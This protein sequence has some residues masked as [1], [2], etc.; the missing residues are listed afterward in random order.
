MAARGMLGSRRVASPERLTDSPG[1]HIP[2][3]ARIASQL[4]R[5][6]PLTSQNAFRCVEQTGES[7]GANPPTRN[8][9]PLTSGNEPA[10]SPRG[11]SDAV[12]VRCRQ[13]ASFE[14]FRAPGS[15]RP[16]ARR[17]PESDTHV[18]SDH[19]VGHGAHQLRTCLSYQA[20]VF[21]LDALVARRIADVALHADDHPGFELA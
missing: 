4:P 13:V 18:A 10:D 11:D 20:L 7:C 15:R 14:R 9:P 12:S 8:S 1:T 21:E 17:H 5:R 3:D 6:P 2:T 19:V 16:P